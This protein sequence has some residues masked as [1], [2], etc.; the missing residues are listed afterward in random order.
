[1]SQP[2]GAIREHCPKNATWE[3]AL[4]RMSRS[5]SDHGEERKG[6]QGMKKSLS[7]GSKL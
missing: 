6:I 4:E 1:M 3:L 5:L 7:R 2:A